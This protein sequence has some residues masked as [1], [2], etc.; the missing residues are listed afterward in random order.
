MPQ[1]DKQNAPSS[2]D[3]PELNSLR[4]TE[5]K[6][7]VLYSYT[8]PSFQRR[9]HSLV[10]YAVFSLI[11][12][13]LLGYAIV[14]QSPMMFVVFLLLVILT[15]LTIQ[16]EP[17]TIEVTITDQGITIS[18]EDTYPY[19]AIDFF[20]ILYDEDMAFISLFLKEGV[21][22]YVKIPLGSEDA[23]DIADILTQFLDRKDGQERLVDKLD[24]ILQL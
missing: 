13:I 19:T 9:E 6:E 8:S 7:E 16:T 14:S 15:L 21:I 1:K 18:E 22:R 3:A 23:E 2:E 17:E 20:G 11:A 4:Q 12:L 24:T 10:W 5:E